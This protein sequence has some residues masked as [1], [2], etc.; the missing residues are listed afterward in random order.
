MIK[1]SLPEKLNLKIGDIIATNGDSYKVRHDIIVIGTITTVSSSKIII[2]SIHPYEMGWV[3]YPE[4]PKMI[5]VRLKSLASALNL[6]STLKLKDIHGNYVLPKK[7]RNIHSIP[8]IYI[9]H[10]KTCIRPSISVSKAPE[11]KADLP[12]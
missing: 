2:D 10:S 4:D 8:D 11:I 3:I 9:D 5:I 1:K 6:I 7:K 12:F